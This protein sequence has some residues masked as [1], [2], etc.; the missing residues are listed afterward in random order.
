MH[1]EEEQ[2]I[3]ITIYVSYVVKKYYGKI[4][5]AIID[6]VAQNVQKVFL[7]KI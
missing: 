1:P 3:Q 5:T 6:F 2:H 7:L 4:V